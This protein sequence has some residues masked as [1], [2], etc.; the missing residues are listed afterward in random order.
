ME[1][2]SF[3]ASRALNTKWKKS[4]KKKKKKKNMKEWIEK[5]RLE[6]SLAMLLNYAYAIR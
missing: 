4:E 3:N 6:T 1:S 5:R 2:A